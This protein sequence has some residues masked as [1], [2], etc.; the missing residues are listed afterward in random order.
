MNVPAGYGWAAPCRAPGRA[1]SAS[2]Q[3][4]TAVPS[5]FQQFVAGINSSHHQNAISRSGTARRYP[6]LGAERAARL[7]TAR[8]G[9]TP[10]GSAPHGTVRLGTARHGSARPGSPQPGT[11]RLGTAWHSTARL[12][13]ARPGS[14]RLSSAEAAQRGAAASFST[15]HPPPAPRARPIGSRCCTDPSHLDSLR[16]CVNTFSSHSF[17]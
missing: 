6:G 12:G 7:G 9:S 5:G 8:H 3:Q 14:A 17:T 1:V 4:L 16:P 2:H 10:H 13:S 15:P 11:A